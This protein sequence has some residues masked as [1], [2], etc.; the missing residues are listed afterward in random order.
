MSIEKIA[1]DV[2]VVGSGPGGATTA[3]LLAE[4][5][6]DV[7]L[8][9]EGPHLR[10]NSAPSFSLEEMNQKYR[11][12]GLTPAFGKTQITYIEGRCV[13]GASE[14]NAALFHRPMPETLRE[15]SLKH[16]VDRITAEHLDPYLD[17]TASEM[18]VSK[19]LEGLAPASQRL[20]AGADSLGWKHVEVERFWRY[21]QDGAG[22]SAGQRQSMTESLVPR[23]LAAGCR[24]QADTRIERL[25]LRGQRAGHA[26]AR[27]VARGA[28]GPRLRIDFNDVFVCAGAIH[29]PLVLRSSG[30]KR[31]IG[32]SLRLH[33]MIRVA[34]RFDEAVNDPEF[35]VPVQQVEEFKPHM[36]LGCSHSALPHLALWLAGEV[37]DKHAKLEAWQ[38]MVVF[39]AKVTSTGRGRIRRVPFF[40]DPLVWFQLTDQDM[41]MLGEGLYRLGQLVFA[42]GAREMVNPIEGGPSITNLE[43]LRELRTGLPHG[44]I[45]VTSIHLFCSCPM[46]EDLRRCA[47]DSWGK[48]HGFDNIYLN[49]ASI[50]PGTPGV[51]PQATIMAI[52]RRNVERFLDRG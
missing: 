37:P 25:V 27:R 11:N 48:L 43:Q 46:G 8:V 21:D 13:G 12:V 29:T 45:N 40:G 44:R 28:R 52:A 17:A 42:A 2:L 18:S 23:A 1:C 5:G 14:I 9:E 26:M 39:Y 33:P 16:Q 47:V 30:I 20:V 6:K 19:R 31:N 3:C 7:L 38:Q 10:L 32:N 15:W 49:D 4:A 35:G 41:A 24:L 22:G 51:N 36:T 34:A 50:L